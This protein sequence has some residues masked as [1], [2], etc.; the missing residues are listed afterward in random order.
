MVKNRKTEGHVRG[1][2][3]K[4]PVV[5]AV[6]S[7]LVACGGVILLG[8]LFQSFGKPSR[9]EHPINQEIKALEV[10]AA[11]NCVSVYGAIGVFVF[12]DLQELLDAYRREEDWNSK[13]SSA[14][15]R[16]TVLNSL[17]QACGQRDQLTAQG[18]LTLLVDI[19]DQF[20][21]VLAFLYG[22]ASPLC[23]RACTDN[24]IYS[25]EN[26]ALR[27]KQLLKQHAG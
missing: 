6:L 11:A 15:Q 24:A 27:I 25:L 21:G 12:H 13:V 9:L 2:F 5:Y 7:I 8:G 1:I 4:N 23:N 14:T 3:D 19:G 22:L 17:A 10:R 18:S 16:A 26:Q 20:A